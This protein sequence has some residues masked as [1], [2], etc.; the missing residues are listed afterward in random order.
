MGFGIL[1]LP[2]GWENNERY[3]M[4]QTFHGI[5]IVG[6]TIAYKIKDTLIDNLELKD[7]AAQKE[8]L[9]KNKVKYVILHKKLILPSDS[10][11]TA[12][13]AAV[14]EPVYEDGKNT[15]LKVY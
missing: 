4:Y 2:G 11:D 6:G 13:Y 14:Y 7:L 5:P 12:G 10:I 3:M 8:Q 1:D 15:V 9:I